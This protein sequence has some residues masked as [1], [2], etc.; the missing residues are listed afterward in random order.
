MQLLVE[1]HEQENSTRNFNVSLDETIFWSL[2]HA[3]II[4]WRKAY[5]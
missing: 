4:F 5:F 3:N 2:L 1:D